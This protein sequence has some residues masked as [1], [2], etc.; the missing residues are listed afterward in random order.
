MPRTKRG[1]PLRQIAYL[2]H[3]RLC[4]PIPSALPEP[5]GTKLRNWPI[6]RLTPICYSRE[7]EGNSH[8]HT[9]LMR[10]SGL[11]SFDWLFGKASPNC[12]TQFFCY[13]TNLVIYLILFNNISIRSVVLSQ[14]QSVLTQLRELGAQASY[15]PGGIWG[16]WSRDSVST[17]A[18]PL[19]IT[20]G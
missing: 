8:V 3:L 17:Y 11:F 15:T 7:Y 16:C 4:R 1:A 12:R 20:S 13:T 19:G 6:D 2:P 18:V 9:L 14:H 5:L 10:E